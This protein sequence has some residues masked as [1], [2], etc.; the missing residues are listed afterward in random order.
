MGGRVC[1][2]N[3]LVGQ[4]DNMPEKD[5][6]ERLRKRLE[7]AGWTLA[8]LAEETGENYKNIQRWVS[9]TTTIPATFLVKFARVVPGD[10]STLLT[11]DEKPAPEGRERASMEP[12][13]DAER[14]ELL[15]LV[16]DLQAAIIRGRKVTPPIAGEELAHEKNALQ[17]LFPP[18][19]DVDT[20]PSDEEPRPKSATAG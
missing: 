18:D 19:Q 6:K 16:G 3:P 2:V 17:Q 10:H 9:G 20:P 5:L 12:I 13:E 14:F 7:D 11:G 8:R 15:R 4:R 1:P